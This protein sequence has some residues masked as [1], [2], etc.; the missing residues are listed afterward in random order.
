MNWRAVAGGVTS[1][2][3]YLG[4]LALP[5]FEG[6]RWTGVPLVLATGLV[7]G[8]AAGLIADGGP[9]AGGRH[10]LLSGAGA[11]GCFAGAFWLAFD[12]TIPPPGRPPGVFYGLNYLLAT[13]AGRF[14]AVAAHGPLVV[15]GLALAGGAGIALL[16]LY[17]GRKAP[18]REGRG[19]IEP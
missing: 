1:A 17:A 2:L 8:A 10:G 19:L 11:G 3:V 15:A 16:G 5:V 4:V 18:Q 7:A 12:P 13:N 9:R 6:M 14:P